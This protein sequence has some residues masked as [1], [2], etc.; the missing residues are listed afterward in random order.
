MVC[1]GK[2]TALLCYFLFF[3]MSGLKHFTIPLN[4]TFAHTLMHRWQQCLFTAFARTRMTVEEVSLL[5]LTASLV[6]IFPDVIYVLVSTGSLV[7][8]MFTYG[9]CSF[10][11]FR[12]LDLKYSTISLPYVMLTQ[13]SYLISYSLYTTNMIPRQRHTLSVLF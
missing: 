4:H 5:D 9:Q 13:R 1:N 11:I 2:L 8:H 3:N 6:F 12:L 7:P 10:T